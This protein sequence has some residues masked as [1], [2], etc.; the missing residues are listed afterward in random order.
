MHLMRTKD[1][2][3]ISLFAGLMATGSYFAIPFGPIPITLQSLVCLLSGVILGARR[4]AFSQLIYVLIGV[5][6]LPVF[7]GGAS[8]IGYLFGP[9]GGFLLGFIACAYFVGLVAGDFQNC[10]IKRTAMA[11]CTGVVILY[12]FGLSGLM[13]VTHINISSAIIVGI[14]P[15]IPGEVLKVTAALLIAQLLN[16]V[17]SKHMNQI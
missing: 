2:V 5:I 16:T 14:L 3:L 10:T 17:L 1:M 8:G 11:L 9:T 15:F 13:L 12:V 4:G 6:G 7:A